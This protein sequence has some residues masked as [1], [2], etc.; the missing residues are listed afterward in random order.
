ML[1]RLFPRRNALP[2]GGPVRDTGAHRGAAAALVLLPKGT[3]PFGMVRASE[4][5]ATEDHAQPPAKAGAHRRSDPR[6]P[7]GVAAV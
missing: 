6:A 2:A 3:R 4:I 1:G 7:V 5:N